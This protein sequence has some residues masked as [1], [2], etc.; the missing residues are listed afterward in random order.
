[1]VHF[2]ILCPAAS[3]HLNPMTAL[4]YELRQRGHQVTV[5]GILDAKSKVLAAGLSFWAIGEV[6]FPLGAIPNA[7]AE[8]GQLD[9]WRHFGIV[10][11]GNRLPPI[12]EL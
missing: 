5:V 11:G 12:T 10:I 8:L 3:G 9:G 1:M 2:G 4:G 6:A 7:F